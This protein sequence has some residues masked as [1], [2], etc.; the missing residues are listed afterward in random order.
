[1]AVAN[2]GTFSTDSETLQQT[3]N[4][5]MLP[6]IDSGHGVKPSVRTMIILG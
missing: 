5:S 3:I 1:M 6:S 4:D 2:L